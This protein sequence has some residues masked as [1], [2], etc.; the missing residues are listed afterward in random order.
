MEGQMFNSSVIDVAIGLVFVF[1]L[2]SLV[3]SAVKEGLEAI[4]KRR[5]SDL[6]RGIRELVG[7]VFEGKKS[8]D[9]D[10]S[11]KNA[12]EEKVT[13]ETTDETVAAQF[14]SS[15]YDHGLINSLFAGR[16]GAKG[17]ELPSYIPS[18]NFAL[19]LMDIRNKCLAAD[20]P[21]PLPR[22]VREAF[23]AFTIIGQRNRQCATGY[24]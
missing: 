14:V 24:V 2:L 10:D 3:A 22:Y 12:A 16:Y 5:A 23:D 15:L 20:P 11:D 19:A 17:T 7:N 1:L 18:K 4:F 6:E 8:D 9:K 21:I 13:A